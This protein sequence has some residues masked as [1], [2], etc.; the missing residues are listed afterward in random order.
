[1]RRCM[2]WCGARLLCVLFLAGLLAILAP[3][4]SAQ[5]QDPLPESAPPIPEEQEAP[6]QTPAPAY[7]G[8]RVL[9]V[10]DS[11]A[12]GYL[13]SD[14]PN[15]E[16]SVWIPNSWPYLLSQ[17]MGLFFG[18]YLMVYRGGA[19][20]DAQGW[21]TEE[22]QA[23]PSFRADFEGTLLHYDIYDT[24]HS[25]DPERVETII[26][27]G[28]CNDFDRNGQD[29]IDGVHRFCDTARAMF[30]NA[31][32]YLFYSATAL[33][34]RQQVVSSVWRGAMDRG[35]TLHTTG[36]MTGRYDLYNK[37]TIHPTAAAQR[38]IAQW[39]FDCLQNAETEEQP[40]AQ[41]GTLELRADAY[42]TQCC[43]RGNEPAYDLNG[44]V[45]V[46]QDICVLQNGIVDSSQTGFVWQGGDRC[47]LLNGIIRG[48]YSG[49][50]LHSNGEYYYVDHSKLDLGYTGFAMTPEGVWYYCT[51]G[52]ADR[53][54]TG[55]RTHSNGLQYYV[56]DGV[57]QSDLTGFVEQ[58]GVRYY[59]VRG[60]FVSD[61]S[62]LVQGSDGLWYV[63]E[64]GLFVPDYTGF[65]MTPDCVWH[66]CTNGVEDRSATGLRT[67]S[68]GLQ[69]YFKDGVLQSGQ[70]GLAEQNGRR[71]Y[72]VDGQFVEDYNGL[73][74]QSDGRWYMVKD[75]VFDPYFN[76]DYED[77]Q[78]ISHSMVNGVSA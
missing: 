16:G 59:I 20:F 45:Q 18:E 28:G 56:K 54:V 33:P 11:Y 21:K 67:H 2:V 61:S 22:E 72:L 23:D 19:G 46:G 74:Q 6:V 44:M 77:P 26:L 17:K 14:D 1:M 3:G 75:G 49:L 40:P 43:Y 7:F 24:Q 63:I 76:G 73:V 12:Q 27:M 35:L 47:Y 53:G 10:G 50:V 58:D 66:Y 78:G 62:G 13:A 68:N 15:E 55:L 30:P 60:Q 9:F 38:F 41:N 32:I 51:D 29:I 48:G 57:L 25:V 34:Q 4:V 65:A 39:I 71:Y 70:T 31:K 37:D 36:Q 64:N 8:P 69:Y 42:G 5:E 52:F